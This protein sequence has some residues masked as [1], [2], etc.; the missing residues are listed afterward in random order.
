MRETWWPNTCDT[1]R[2]YTSH[3]WLLMQHWKCSTANHYR[4]VISQI[5]YFYKCFSGLNFVRLVGQFSCCCH[6]FNE[7]DNVKNLLGSSVLYLVI[8]VLSSHQYSIMKTVRCLLSENCIFIQ[9][10]FNQVQASMKREA[11]KYAALIV[12]VS[13]M[14]TVGHLTLLMMKWTDSRLETMYVVVALWVI[15][16]S[17]FKQTTY[18]SK[19]N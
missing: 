16:N 5:S 12:M 6:T 18:F 11:M 19:I 2:W 15:L 3:N 9:V 7:V 1:V 13:Q 14:E 8:P 4:P 17:T 10:I